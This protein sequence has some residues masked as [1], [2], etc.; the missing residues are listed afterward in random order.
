MPDEGIV[1]INNLI[2]KTQLESILDVSPIGVSISRYHDSKIIYANSSLGKLWGGPVKKIVGT[3]SINYYHDQDD[4]LWVIDQLKQNRPLSNHEMEMNRSDGTTIWCQVNMV[5]ALIDNEKVILTWFNDINEFRHAQIQLKHM[6]SH[7]SLTGL[8]NR[9]HFNEF[10]IDA[11]SRSKRLREP[12]CLIYLDLDDFKAVNDDIGHHF[13]D[14]LLQEVAKRI[15]S[16]LR[17]TDFVARLGGDEFA[18]IIETLSGQIDAEQVAQKILKTV[19][20]PYEK[21]SS[22]AIISISIGITFFGPELM[23]TDVLIRRADTAMYRAKRSGKGRVCVYDPD[24]DGP[25][26]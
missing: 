3:N 13:G 15:T 23:E 14:F 4:I 18:V 12:G 26:N 7:D 17:E 9:M 2:S 5:A 8:A 1:T 10:I 22:K 21:E 19:K 24:L 11:I 20:I 25:I 6:A 16:V